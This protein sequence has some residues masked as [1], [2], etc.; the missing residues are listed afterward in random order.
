MSVM[1]IPEKHQFVSA[2]NRFGLTI[3]AAEIQSVLKYCANSNG[4]ETGGILIGR[5]SQ[6]HNMA[7]VT[8]VSGPPEDSKSGSY[9]FVRGIKGLQQILNRLWSQKEYYIGEWH[10]HPYAA[11]IPSNTDHQ[12]MAEFSCDKRM[13]CPE[14]ILLIIGG[15]PTTEWSI[16]VIVYPRSQKALELAKMP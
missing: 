8:R 13:K 2:E 10:F 6:E 12:Q 7:I 5:Y 3:Y 1:N 4:K 15:N 14:P 11:P 9:F 16:K